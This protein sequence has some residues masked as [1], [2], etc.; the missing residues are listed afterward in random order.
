MLA[1]GDLHIDIKYYVDANVVSDGTIISN[2]ANIGVDAN[3]ERIHIVENSYRINIKVCTVQS[4]DHFVRPEE[5]H[6]WD[7][8]NIPDIPYELGSGIAS[9]NFNH[10]DITYDSYAGIV[11]TSCSY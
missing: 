5:K 3:L 8:V 7:S 9:I 10:P 11:D 4:F 6:Y 1:Q 2:D